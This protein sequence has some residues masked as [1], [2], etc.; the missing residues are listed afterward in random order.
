MSRMKEGAVSQVA[1]GA[2]IRV[3]HGHHSVETGKLAQLAQLL[4][5]GVIRILSPGTRDGQAP[6]GGCLAGRLLPPLQD[7]RAF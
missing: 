1:K 6:S 4:P 3:I 5:S 2:F 7:D